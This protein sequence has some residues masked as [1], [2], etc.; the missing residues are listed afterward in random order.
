MN[1]TF[2]KVKGKT[3]GIKKVTSKIYYK[4]GKK[5]EE[6]NVQE[7]MNKIE[8]YGFDSLAE[9]KVIIAHE[10]AHLV[11]IPHI[12]IQNA[13]MHPLLQKRQINGLFLTK[14][15]IKNFQENF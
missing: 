2:K 14:E 3:F 5:I 9:L 13:L 6:K 10:I 11:G 1:R 15:D 7:S 8:I 4:N 12:E